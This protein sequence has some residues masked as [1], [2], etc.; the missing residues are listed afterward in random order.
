MTLGQRL[1]A[2]TLYGRTGVEYRD[3]LLPALSRSQVAA[4]EWVQARALHSLTGSVVCH[5]VRLKVRVIAGGGGSALRD[6]RRVASGAT[7]MA[8]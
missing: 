5:V 7:N 4:F 6:A 3:A 2:R 1:W 8:G